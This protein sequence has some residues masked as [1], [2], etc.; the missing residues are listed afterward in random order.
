MADGKQNL[1]LKSL[2]TFYM[3]PKNCAL[4]LD[5]LQSQ[6]KYPSLRILDWLGKWTPAAVPK[7]WR[8]TSDL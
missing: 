5:V 7:D 2:R 1:L 6:H 8:Q 4:F 3:D